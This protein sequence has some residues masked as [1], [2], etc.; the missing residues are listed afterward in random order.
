MQ[1]VSNLYPELVEEEVEQEI[2]GSRNDSILIEICN[3]FAGEHLV[4]Y[5]E[6]TS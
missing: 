6:I 1:D 3:P 4:I 2:L 5:I